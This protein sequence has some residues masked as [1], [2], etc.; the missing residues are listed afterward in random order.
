MQMQVSQNIIWTGQIPIMSRQIPF[1]DVHFVIGD[2]QVKPM[3][4]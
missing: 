3:E 2:G 4:G 1:G